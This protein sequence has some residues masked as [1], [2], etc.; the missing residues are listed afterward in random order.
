MPKEDVQFTFDPSTVAYCEM[1]F[2]LLSHC[3]ICG[4]RLG[5][6]AGITL[7]ERLTDE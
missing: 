1:D 6:I 4:A 7:G 2:V 3:A 5:N